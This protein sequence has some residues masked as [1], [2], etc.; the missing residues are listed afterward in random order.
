[1]LAR[2]FF[3]ALCALLALPSLAQ[4]APPL[5]QAHRGGS[6]LDGTPRFPENTLPAF[7]SAARAGYVLEMDA[8]LTSDRVPV[9][10][11]DATLD[12]TTPC[13]GEI[14]EKTLAQ[15]RAC[16]PDVLGSPGNGLATARANPTEAVPTLAEVLALA[17][18]EGAFVNLEI[19]NQPRDPDFDPGPAFANSVLDVLAASKIAPERVIVQSFWPPNLTV[20]RSRLPRV[21]TSLLTLAASNEGGPSFAAANNYDWISPGGVPP[22]DYVDEAH[23]LGLKVVPYTLNTVTDI[24]AARAVGVEAIISDDPALAERALGVTRSQLA[25]DELA[26]VARIKA[27]RYASD[28]SRGALLRVAIRGEDRG[29]GLAGLQLEVRLNTNASTRWRPVGRETLAQGRNFRGRPGATYLFRLRARDRVGNLSTYVHARTSVPVDGDSPRVRYSPGW[30]RLPSEV[31]YAGSVR[32]AR[33]SGA[34]ATFRFRGARAA[35]IAPRLRQGGRIL[36]RIGRR[37]RVVS[38]RG[39]ARARRVVFRS[40]PLRP[41]RHKLT[42]VAL[43]GGKVELDALAVEQGPPA[44]TDQETRGP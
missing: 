28:T 1:M 31:A 27:P 40:G 6:V 44:P 2:A 26:P 15:V 25:P 42:V 19:K 37:S 23:G 34:S 8:K 17:E 30:T 21:E 36:V 11:H 5:L 13:S 29:S 33:R 41:G 32:R 14:A 43:G 7:R 9:V 24:R 38:L 20:S 35:L 18:L 4:S 3:A 12:R 10:F 16:K 39:R 22:K